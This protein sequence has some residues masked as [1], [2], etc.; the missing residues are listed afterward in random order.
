MELADKL[1]LLFTAAVV[2]CG[3]AL[4]GPMDRHS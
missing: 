2:L 4:R 3:V 1:V